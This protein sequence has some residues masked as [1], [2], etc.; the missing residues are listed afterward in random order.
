MRWF[1]L[2]IESVL[3]PSSKETNHGKTSTVSPVQHKHTPSRLPVV[4]SVLAAIF[5]G[6]VNSS[7]DFNIKEEVHMNASIIKAEDKPTVMGASTQ[8]EVC[9]KQ[10]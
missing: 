5:G 7:F 10:G 1:I 6:S 9:R 4:L 8:V 2:Y 3:F